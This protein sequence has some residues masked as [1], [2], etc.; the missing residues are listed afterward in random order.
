MK[1]KFIK[2]ML[3]IIAIGIWAIVYQNY[4]SIDNSNKIQ[5]VQIE[6]GK[7]DRLGPPPPPWENPPQY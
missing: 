4:Q 7:I 3:L 1:D 2:T 6:G 5:K